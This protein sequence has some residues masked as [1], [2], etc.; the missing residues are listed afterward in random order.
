MAQALT[1]GEILD[2][3]PL[4]RMQ[5]STFLLCGLVLVLDGFDAQSLGFLAPSIAKT[6]RVP[7]STFGPIFGAALFGLMIAAMGSGPIADRW[8][9]KWP[10]IISAL[11]FGIFTIL[12]ARATSFNEL[13]LFRFLTGLGLGGSM[14]NVVSLTSEYVP[15][16]LV[17]VFVGMLFCGM[18]LGALLGGTAGAVMLPRWGWQSVLYLGGCLPFVIALILIRILPESVRF[19]ATTTSGEKEV[20]AILT[21]ISPE[22]A[23]AP[24]RNSS[25]EREAHKGMPVKHLF[26]EGRALG[27]LL[28]WVPYFMNLLIIYFIVSW[29][30][31]LLQQSALPISAGINAIVMFSLGGIAGS[32]IE[33][34]LMNWLGAVVLLVFEF[35]ISTLLIASLAFTVSFTLIM[36]VTFIVGFTVQGAQAGLNALVACFYPTTI[37]STGVGWALGVGRVG[38]IVGPVL[39]GMLLSAGWHPR[40]IFLAGALPAFLA[41]LSIMAT[42]RLRGNSSAYSNELDPEVMA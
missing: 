22:L 14:P 13:L 20:R 6:L 8:G 11:T 35:G 39:A 33:G 32:L 37:R 30:P 15:R 24:I 29:L 19:L 34:K 18:P 36:G 7:V 23:D 17:P 1:V 41:A 31:A 38:S 42:A 5:L 10:I 21:R 2:H 12:T 28:L 3:R 9:R 16:R 4:S 25:E 26:T 40:Q 27:T